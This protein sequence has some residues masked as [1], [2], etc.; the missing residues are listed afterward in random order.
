MATQSKTCDHCGT[1]AKRRYAVRNT[2]RGHTK[3]AMVGSSCAKR[4]PRAN[5]SD[6]IREY[7]GKP[8]FSPRLDALQRFSNGGD[9]DPEMDP[10]VEAFILGLFWLDED[11]NGI[12]SDTNHH[13]ELT[14]RLE[15][16]GITRNA[17][18]LAAAVYAG[19]WPDWL[20]HEGSEAAKMAWTEWTRRGGSDR[21]DSNP[22]V[23]ILSAVDF[24][25]EK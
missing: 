13:A 1:P 3:V 16:R 12:S 23:G 5:Q 2:K 9:D 22:I 4:F 25:V 21:A 14:S 17:A 8:L 11:I 18:S 24:G 20:E 19:Y 15:K 6:L 7:Q 10:E